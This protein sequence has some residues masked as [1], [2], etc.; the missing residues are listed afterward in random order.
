MVNDHIAAAP[1]CFDKI[2]DA[3]GLEFLPDFTDEDIDDLRVWLIQ[4]AVEMVENGFLAQV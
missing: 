1:I 3:Y 4:T 2:I